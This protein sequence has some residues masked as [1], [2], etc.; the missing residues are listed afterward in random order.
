MRRKVLF[1]LFCFCLF[2]LNAFSAVILVTYYSKG[3]H[4]EKMAIAVAE[5]VKTV[6]NVTVILKD[7]DQTTPEDILQADA[8]IVGSPVYNGNVAPQVL[9]FINT[10]P[11]KNQPLK[12][13]I[14][15]AFCTGGGISAGEEAVQ[16]SIL[17]AM[18][19]FNMIVVGGPN[20]QSA[21]GASAVT[22]EEPFDQDAKGVNDHFLQKG[23]DLGKRVAELVST[24]KN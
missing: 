9:S 8:I 2:H 14:G 16:Q 13:K 7:I 11:F 18:L 4:T 3:G 5:G 22:G 24:F 23:R 1:S 21:F 12:N 10:W 15:A 17:R 20:W 6:E 19:V